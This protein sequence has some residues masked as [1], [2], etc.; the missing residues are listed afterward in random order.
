[1]R[2]IFSLKS[3]GN[4]HG[5]LVRVIAIFFLLYTGADLAS[6]QLCNEK[7]VNLSSIQVSVPTIERAIGATRTM[8]LVASS[9]NSQPHRPSDQ[10][11]DKDDDCFCCC[12]HVLPGVIVAN[13]VVFDLR[14]SS[15]VLEHSS[16]PSPPLRGTFRPPRFA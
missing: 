1:M 3:T 10:T 2:T 4:R 16:V 11:P 13:V 7:L 14:T 12:A 5:V 8:T 6:P 9:D 15:F